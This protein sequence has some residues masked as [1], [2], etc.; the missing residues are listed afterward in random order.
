MC[1]SGSRQR[2]M[3]WVYHYLLAVLGFETPK[4]RPVA[5]SRVVAVTFTENAACEMRERV[6]STPDGSHAKAL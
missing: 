5:P 6:A 1:R 4:S 2:R 3:L